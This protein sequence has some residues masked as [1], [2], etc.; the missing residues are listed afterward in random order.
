LYFDLAYDKDPSD[1]G[2]Y[3]G[4][5]VDTKTA[6]GFIP[7]D[8]YKGDLFNNMGAPV[9]PKDLVNKVRLTPVGAKNILGIQGQLWSETVIGNERMEHYLFPKMLGLVE[10]AW[11]KNPS[12]ASIENESKRKEAMNVSWGEFAA[13][14]G[15]FEFPKLSYINGGLNYRI[16]P[17]G[18]KVVDGKLIINHDFPSFELRYTLDGSEPKKDS[19]L[20]TEAVSVN[21]E[22]KQIK[23][24][25]F[26]V[27]GRASNVSVIKL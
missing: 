14:V 10:R 13:K 1:P 15:Y 6:W 2:Y 11:A 18:A 24:A 20:Y 12:W 8:I 7:M 25:A 5:F 26:N 9:N 17:P 22:V 21:Q 27:N 4:G 19:P 16:A 23:V 3:W